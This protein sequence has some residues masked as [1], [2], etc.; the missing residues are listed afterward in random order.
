MSYSDFKCNRQLEAKTRLF[1]KGFLKVMK[2]EWLTMFNNQEINRIISGSHSDFSVE[3]L[4]YNTVLN[5]YNAKDET[6][7][8]LWETLR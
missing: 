2:A 5:G 3:D 6:L 7:Q 4:K 1:R 8:Y